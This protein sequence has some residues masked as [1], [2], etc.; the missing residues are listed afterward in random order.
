MQTLREAA[1][2]TVIPAKAAIQNQ[3]LACLPL[4]SFFRGDP[5]PSLLP[6]NHSRLEFPRHRPTI[7]RVDRC[8]IDFENPAVWTSLS[9]T[10]CQAAIEFGLVE[11]VDPTPVPTATMNPRSDIDDSGSVNANDLFLFLLDWMKASGE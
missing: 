6:L 4:G 10:V 2:P 9:G 1:S 11:S 7:L 5:L 3:D 8:A